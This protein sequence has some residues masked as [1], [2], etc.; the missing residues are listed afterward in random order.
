M[1]TTKTNTRRRTRSRTAKK[2]APPNRGG[3]TAA[4]GL[5]TSSVFLQLLTAASFVGMCEYR[6]KGPKDCFFQWTVL[7]LFVFGGG[8]TVAALFVQA[9]R[10]PPGGQIGTAAIG[11][12][13]QALL[14]GAAGAGASPGEP[15]VA[16]A[17]PELDTPEEGRPKRQGR[18]TN[19]ARPGSREDLIG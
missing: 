4:A 15:P 18:P 9:L 6:S 2:P 12:L 14:S 10:V 11:A 5:I 1:P 19:R 7:G 16:P 8:Q 13:A 17:A 3:L